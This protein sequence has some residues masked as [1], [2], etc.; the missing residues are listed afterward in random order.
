[1]KMEH[2][3]KQDLESPENGINSSRLCIKNPFISFF[4]DKIRRDGQGDSS[5]PKLFIGSLGV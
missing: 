1:M 5:H 2:N 3:I 4:L